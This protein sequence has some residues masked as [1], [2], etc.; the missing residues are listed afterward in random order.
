MKSV[1]KFEHTISEKLY[2]FECD[3]NS[4]TEH[5]KEALFQ[6][7]KEV[8]H[9]EDQI[10]IYLEQQK[11]SAAAAGPETTAA[12]AEVASAPIEAA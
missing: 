10:K 9:I 8:G 6:I 2:V 1:T 4:P 7:L 3:P 5:V 12:P 11:A